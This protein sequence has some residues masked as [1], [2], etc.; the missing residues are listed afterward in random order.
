MQLSLRSHHFLTLNRLHAGT[1]SSPC[2][3]DRQTDYEYRVVGNDYNTGSPP[4]QSKKHGSRR[5]FRALQW[6]IS[7]APRRAS[8]SS[9]TL[10]SSFLKSG[11]GLGNVRPA[12][13]RS[14][15]HSPDPVAGSYR[16]TW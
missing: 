9:M 4:I 10:S 15:T 2:L 3:M 7:Y 8:S 12:G 13:S 5:D 6:L 14:K 11:F 1:S 16:N